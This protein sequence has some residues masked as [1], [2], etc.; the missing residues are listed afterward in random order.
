M[1]R[2]LTGSISGNLAIVGPASNSDINFIT[3]IGTFTESTWKAGSVTVTAGSLSIAGFLGEIS[4]STLSSGPADK[5]SVDVAGHLSIAGPSGSFPT[6]IVA[7]AF[8]GGTGNSGDVAVRAGS[9][10]I[11]NGGEIS[12]TNAG[13]GIGGSVTVSSQG[14]LSLSGGA[15]VT[16]ST[17]GPGNG[18]SVQVTAQGVL[19]LSGGAGILALAN[20]TASG[21]AGSVTVNA[22][23]ITVTSGAQLASTTAGTSRGGTVNV[24]T[25]GALLLENEAQIAASATGPKIG[26]GRHGDG[27]GQYPDHRRA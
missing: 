8:P 2:C 18:G 4:S 1:W 6:G 11:I 9:L 10:S 25:S 13:F 26:V 24:N 12:A 15:Q 16:S 5:V 22:P 27:R 23:Q 20:A 3:G 7:A 14:P 17:A 21:N 19:S